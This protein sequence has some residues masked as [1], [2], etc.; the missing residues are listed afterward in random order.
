MSAASQLTLGLGLPP[1]LG[2]EDFVVG[3]GNRAAL[4]AIDAWPAW[5][6]GLVLLTGPEGSGKTH[7]TRIWA[8]AS[9]APVL[10]AADLAG[11]DWGRLVAA[12]PI[13]VEDVDATPEVATDLFHLINEVRAV[14][15]S[16]LVTA[17]A[18]D[19]AGW[20]DLA[21][22][23]SRL[24]AAQPVALAEPDET[25]LRKVLVKLFADR[26]LAVTP[27]LLDYLLRRMERSFAAAARIVDR[28]DQSALSTG[29]PLSR[30][31]A[32]EALANEP[33]F[34]IAA[35]AAEAK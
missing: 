6:N 17:R 22:L 31:L 3:D 2:R 24:R 29:R 28:I 26:Q 15:G 1:A 12:G 9:A 27:V 34:S 14:G 8:E 11:R 5:P 19:P 25:F 10:A 4:A 13:A 16:L 20:T 23:I 7:L 18:A 21:D 32:A 30:Q 33:G 35:D